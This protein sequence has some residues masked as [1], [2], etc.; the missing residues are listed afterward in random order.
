[1]KQLSGEIATSYSVKRDGI[2]APLHAAFRYELT[3]FLALANMLVVANEASLSEQLLEMTP[4]VFRSWLDRVT[5]E[6]SVLG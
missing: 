1:V 5:G 3:G 2:L 6:G 4:D